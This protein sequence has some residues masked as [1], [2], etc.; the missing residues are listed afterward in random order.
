MLDTIGPDHPVVFKFLS[1]IFPNTF[2]SN[3]FYD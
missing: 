1:L 2:D 3:F